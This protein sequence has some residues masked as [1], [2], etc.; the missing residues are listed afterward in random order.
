MT[1]K[2]TQEQAVNALHDDLIRQQRRIAELERQ[3][4]DAVKGKM[5]EDREIDADLITISNGVSKDTRQ[6]FIS[7]RW[8]THI[9]QVD[10]ETAKKLGV[11]L[12]TAAE[13]A[14]YESLIFRTLADSSGDVD[15]SIAF[16]AMMRQARS[17]QP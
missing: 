14:D 12:I 2:E 7:I 13:T 6:G 10:S 16:L 4:A 17:P 15:G 3:L 8:G 1:P 11:D 5:P 9:A